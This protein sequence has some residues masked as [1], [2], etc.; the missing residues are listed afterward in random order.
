MMEWFW[1]MFYRT[2]KDEKIVKYSVTREEVNDDLEGQVVAVVGNSRAL[3]QKNFG[4]AIDAADIVIRIN[5]APMPA[6]LSHGIKT[7][8]L[9]LA[10][11]LKIS[12]GW[13]INPDRVLWMSPKRKRLP[14]WVAVRSG[15]FLYPQS[16]IETLKVHLM[17]PPTTGLM[18][19][20]L[21]AKS[22]ATSI[23]L[24]GFDFFSSLSLTGHR[25]AAQ[26]PHDF[27]AEKAWV[28]ALADRD[29]RLTICQ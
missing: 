15:F 14:L 7:N 9:A 25:T 28:Q 27:A 17:A 13:R 29:S 22:K 11:A 26:V 5:S 10:T 4:E 16:E 3:A 1:F 8:W 20:D 2:F 19:I 24:Y 6:P 21:V 12:E 18:I 23:R